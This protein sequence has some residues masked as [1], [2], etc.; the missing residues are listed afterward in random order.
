MHMQNSGRDV[1]V[2]NQLHIKVILFKF[3]AR[4]Q[5]Q[6]TLVLRSENQNYL[7]FFFFS[8]IWASPKAHL[9]LEFFQ[10]IIIM[11]KD[12]ELQWLAARIFKGSC[13]SE[14]LTPIRAGITQV[15]NSLCFL[16]TFQTLWF[17][18]PPC[19]TSS[20]MHTCKSWVESWA[21]RDWSLFFREMLTE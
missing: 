16:W 11:W 14:Y 13:K 5:N 6:T 7:F 12:L 3:L 1:K 21:P 4:I 15:L 9:V 20:R 2:K 17:L 19:H 10:E 8:F 18:S